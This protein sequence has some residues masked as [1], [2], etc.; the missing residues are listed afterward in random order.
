[1]LLEREFSP[2]SRKGRRGRV[3]FSLL[4]SRQQ[5]KRKMPFKQFLFNPKNASRA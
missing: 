2:Q 3:F 5:R 4:L 1:M